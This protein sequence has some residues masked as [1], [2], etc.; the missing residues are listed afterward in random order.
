MAEVDC[1]KFKINIKCAWQE[2]KTVY[3][4]KFTR[5]NFEI[6][7]KSHKSINLH[8]AVHNQYFPW[9]VFQ[10]RSMMPPSYSSKSNANFWS[11]SNVVNYISYSI[12]AKIED[13]TIFGNAKYCDPIPLNFKLCKDIWTA[14]TVDGF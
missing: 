7:G 8:F 12:Q 3:R 9:T 11:N 10:N 4:V 5:K 2:E 1:V 14:S 6:R 13:E